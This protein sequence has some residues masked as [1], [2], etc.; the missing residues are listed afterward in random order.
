MIPFPQAAWRSHL[1]PDEWE[2][3][4]EAWIA[5]AQGHISL[6]SSDF[7]RISSQDTSLPMFLSSFARE[8]TLS[9]DISTSLRFVKLR[10]QCLLLSYRLLDLDTPPELLLT[11]EFLADISKLYGKGYGQRFTTNVWK[12]HTPIVEASMTTVKSFLIKELDAGLGGDLK[13]AEEQLRRLSYLLNASPEASAF[14]MA[15]SDFVDALISCYKLMNPPLRQIIVTTAYLCLIGLTEGEK[16]NFSSL[17]DQLYSLKGAAETHKTGPTSVNDSLVAELVTVTPII[18]QIQQRIEVN[19]TG[20]S[21]A[22]S[23]LTVLEGFRKPGAN[24]R[25]VRRKGKSEK[26]KGIARDDIDSAG[27]NE[28]VHI[29]RMSLISQVQDLFPD[30]GSGFVVKLLDEYSDNVEQVIAHLLEGS[31]PAHLD[32]AD[33]SETLYDMY[34]SPYTFLT[35]VGVYYQMP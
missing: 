25:Q 14:F 11:W 12:R 34:P 18:K 35:L 32:R 10:K 7:V 15:G 16:P 33:R 27:S 9:P 21:R 26:G 17:V 3:C 20:S 2:A 29:H 8:T 31:L 22:K 13:R 4:L 24:R 6:S 5:L 19:G 30:L 28:R 1:V 23:V